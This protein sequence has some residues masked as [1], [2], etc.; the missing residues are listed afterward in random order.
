VPVADA[1][2]RQ[3]PLNAAVI[4]EDLDDFVGCTIP[5]EVLESYDRLRAGQAQYIEPD[6]GPQRLLGVPGAQ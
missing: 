3:I 4:S 5:D 2:G 6:I 1:P